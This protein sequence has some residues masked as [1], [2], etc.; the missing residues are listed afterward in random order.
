MN[1]DKQKQ[2][3]IHS[4]QELIEYI[5]RKEK[6]KIKTLLHIIKWIEEVV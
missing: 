5:P 6:L 4:I 1:K 3:T 2:K